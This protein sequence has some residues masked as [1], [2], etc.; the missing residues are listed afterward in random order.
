MF[1][2]HDRGGYVSYGKTPVIQRVKPFFS[3]FQ[4]LVPSSP[5]LEDATQVKLAYL[6]DSEGNAFKPLLNSPAFFNVEGTFES[7]DTIDI[8]LED[9]LQTDDASLVNAAVGINLDNFNTSAKVLYGARRVDPI[10]TTQKVSIN[11]VSNVSDA[12]VSSLSFL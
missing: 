12:F 1:P 8:A 10:L 2:S 5:E 9:T 4:L 3:Y 6:I 11:D 7:G